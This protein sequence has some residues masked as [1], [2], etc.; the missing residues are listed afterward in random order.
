M[1]CLQLGRRSLIPFEEVREYYQSTDM[2]FIK[3]IGIL[4]RAVDVLAEWN[5][6]LGSGEKRSSGYHILQSISLLDEA[7][8]IWKSG[9][10]N[11]WGY[12]ESNELL[13]DQGSWIIPLLMHPGA[14]AVIH[15]YSCLSVAYCW[16]L[17]RLLR[18]VLN[19]ALL[20]ANDVERQGMGLPSKPQSISTITKHVEDICSSV[21]AHLRGSIPG[22]YEA[23]QEQDIVGLRQFLLFA[24]LYAVRK[25]L[26][27][28]ATNPMAKVR[29]DWV[30]NLLAFLLNLNHP[31]RSPLS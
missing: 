23:L 31:N 6:Y 19:R 14:P 20:T 29:L 11:D 24:P 5:E 17:Y 25:C 7:L 26:I 2:P 22:R 4:H 1:S 30:E 3:L 12:T 10:S 9:R 8:E 28:F 21:Y 27:S 16:N 13:T 15:Q 18:L